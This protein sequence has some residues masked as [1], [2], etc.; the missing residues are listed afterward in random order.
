MADNIPLNVG[1]GGKTLAADEI[2]GI[3][4][5]R[6]KLISGPDG[7]NSGDVSPATPLPVSGDILGLSRGLISGVSHVNKFGRSTNVDSGVATDI[8]DGADPTLDQDIWVAPTAA[9]VHQIVSDSAS[10]DGSPGGIGARTLRVFGLTGWGTAEVTEDITLNGTTNVATSNSYV[11]IHRLEVLTK[12]ATNV[13]VGTITATADTDGTITAQMQPGKGVTQMA[14][15]GIPSVQT[16]FMTNYYASFAKSAGAA[17]A[18][19]ISLLFNP[20]PDS[21]LTNFV[22]KHT[23]SIQSTGTSHFRHVF[24]PFNVFPGPAILKI[25]GDGSA[26]DLTVDAGFDLILCTN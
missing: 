22:V 14:I 21:E 19:D 3:H 9:R 11:I 7:T 16:A 26:N 15:Y 10:D 13:N 25:Q 2:S 18:V 8:W 4:Y 5:Q 17:G 24:N 1:A 6:V 12:G 20:E 23:Q